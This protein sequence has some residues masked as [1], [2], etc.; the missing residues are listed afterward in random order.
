MY[1]F[2]LLSSIDTL[3]TVRYVKEEVFFMMF[4]VQLTHCRTCGRDDIVDKEEQGIF[5]SQMNSLAD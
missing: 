4:L 3:V 2:F 1:L 5:W